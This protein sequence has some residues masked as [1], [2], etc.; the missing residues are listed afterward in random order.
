[1]TRTMLDESIDDIDIAHMHCL[2][3]LWCAM[4]GMS[5]G[6]LHDGT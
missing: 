5:C 6:P 4:L 1:M 3:K 2:P